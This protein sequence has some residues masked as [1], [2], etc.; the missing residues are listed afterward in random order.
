VGNPD[1]AAAQAAFTAGAGTLLPGLRYAPPAE[2]LLALEPVW[3][4]LDGLAERDKA[5]LVASLVTVISHDGVVTAEEWELLRT[6]C[7]LLHCPL[8]PLTAAHG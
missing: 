3:P 8:P 2:G 1:P 4:A 7:A 6:V 5:A